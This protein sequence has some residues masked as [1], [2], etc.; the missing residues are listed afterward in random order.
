MMNTSII[1][2]SLILFV[3]VCEGIQATELIMSAHITE[4]HREAEAHQGSLSLPLSLM[5]KEYLRLHT[6]HHILW[7][8][9]YFCIFFLCYVQGHVFSLGYHFVH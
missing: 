4:V 2:Q 8:F 5:H 1:S 6:C 3:C 9:S 7:F